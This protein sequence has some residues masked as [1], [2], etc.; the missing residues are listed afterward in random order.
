MLKGMVEAIVEGTAES[1]NPIS[2]KQ[3]KEA[4]KIVSAACYMNT[5][6]MMAI[7]KNGGKVVEKTKPKEYE[8]L[9]SYFH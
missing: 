1:K 9:E 8:R 7:L 2:A 4:I 5:E 6:A 3:A